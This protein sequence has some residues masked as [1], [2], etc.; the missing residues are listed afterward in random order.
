[1][2]DSVRRRVRILVT[3]LASMALVGMVAANG[4]VAQGHGSHATVTCKRVGKKKLSCPKKELHGRRG[5]QGAQGASGPQGPAGPAGQPG[6]AGPPGPQGASGV[7]I[8]LIFRGQI[9]TQNTPILNLAGLLINASCGPSEAATSLTGVS[10]IPG[11]VLR[12]TDVVSGSIQGS[13][14][15]VVNERFSLTPGGLQNNY[16]LTYLA[17]NG[18][19][20]LTANYGIANGGMSLVNVSCAVFGTVQLAA[21]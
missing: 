18:S 17:G 21:G 19:T 8:P 2:N 3:A 12:A 11:S 16:V 14:S 15:T 10:E 20:I 4:A 1:M 7:T 6:P 13:N 5:K 9:P